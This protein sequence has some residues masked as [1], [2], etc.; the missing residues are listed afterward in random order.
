MQ[1]PHLVTEEERVSFVK[2]IQGDGPSLGLPGR[3]YTILD[4]MNAEI[5]N[6]GGYLGG[7]MMN[8]GQMSMI[9]GMPGAGKSFLTSLLATKLALGE[10]FGP[11]TTKKARVLYISQEMSEAIPQR[12]FQRLLAGQWPSDDPDESLKWGN[13]DQDLVT[14]FQPNFDL[15]S[16]DGRKALYEMVKYYR[17][18]VVFIDCFSMIHT[19]NENSN[20]EMNPWLSMVLQRTCMELGCHVSFIHHFKKRFSTEKDDIRGASCI[21][22]IMDTIL[23]LIKD[24]EIEGSGILRVSKIRDGAGRPPIR[25]D[26]T[27]G[28]E[29][30]LLIDFT[31]AA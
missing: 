10:R 13:F 6:P 16:G 27:D 4:L 8:P 21:R 29:D 22:A 18:D 30:R 2:R 11:L 25:Y 26:I 7:N 19:A 12:R 14:I 23:F 5:P 15:A 24:E 31:D 9:A 17:S 20:D 28:L 3:H 1:S